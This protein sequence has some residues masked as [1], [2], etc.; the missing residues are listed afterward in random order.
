MFFTVLSALLR[1][2][3]LEWNDHK[4]TNENNN[5]PDSFQEYVATIIA[6]PTQALEKIERYYEDYNSQIKNKLVGN[7]PTYNEGRKITMALLHLSL[8]SL[9]LGPHMHV[10]TRSNQYMLEALQYKETS[11]YNSLIKCNFCNFTL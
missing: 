7:R 10:S 3:R 4:S 1:L 6:R 2:W 8:G 9:D 5:A 11:G